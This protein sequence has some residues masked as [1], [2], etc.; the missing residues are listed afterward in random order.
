MDSKCKEQQFVDIFNQTLKAQSFKKVPG[1]ERGTDEDYSLDLLNTTMDMQK[2]ACG[3]EENQAG[4]LCFY[5]PAGTGK[6]EYAHWLSKQLDKPL[7]IK[8]SSDLMSC[9]VGETERNLARA[10]EEADSDNAILFLDEVDSFLQDRSNARHSWQVSEVNELLSQM[11]AFSGIFIATTNLV[12]ILDKAALRRFDAKIKFD[13]LT[14]FQR[15][16]MFQTTC[17]LLDIGQPESSHLKVMEKLENIATGDFAA[18]KRRHRFSAIGNPDEL[19]CALVE[20]SELK[21]GAKL[22]SIGFH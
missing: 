5:G 9:F 3:I 22:R 11:E 13:F 20:E 19:I 16:K 8:K 4:R 10:F 21:A 2:L 6:T 17:D 14:V 1:L 18:M 7:I 12:E 15:M